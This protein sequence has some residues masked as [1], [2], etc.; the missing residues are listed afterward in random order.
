MSNYIIDK[1]SSIKRLDADIEKQ[2]NAKA[3]K[4][5]DM[6]SSINT[7]KNSG[8]VNELYPGGIEA[9]EEDLI[10]FVNE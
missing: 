5:S 8:F 3:S 4:L 2:K 9:L 1:I 10:S 7:T 6:E